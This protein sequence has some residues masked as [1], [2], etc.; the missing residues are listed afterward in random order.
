[1]SKKRCTKIRYLDIICQMNYHNTPK[2]I[3]LMEG[4][5]TYSYLYIPDMCCSSVTSIANL[6]TDAARAHRPQR[7]PCYRSV[8]SSAPLRPNVGNQAAWRRAV[9]VRCRGSIPKPRSKLAPQTTHME[10]T[11]WTSRQLPFGGNRA[12]QAD[13]ERVQLSNGRIQRALS[14]AGTDHDLKWCNTIREERVEKW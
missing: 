4:P 10:R 7:P 11:K 5:L 13:C 6:R 8:M 14:V 3:I 12:R 1:M 2:V 9:E